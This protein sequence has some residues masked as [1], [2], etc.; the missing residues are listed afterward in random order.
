MND[1]RKFQPFSDQ[2]ALKQTPLMIAIATLL[3]D[4]LT[5]SRWILVLLT[6][7]GVEIIVWS[8]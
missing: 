7:L 6:K 1:H 4:K 3:R 5:R 2:K 8:V